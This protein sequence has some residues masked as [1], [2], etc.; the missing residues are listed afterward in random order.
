MPF[1][2]NFKINNRKNNGNKSDNNKE[3]EAK[4]A[5]KVIDIP[6]DE[7]AF[8]VNC[9]KILK[10]D[11]KGYARRIKGI[12][13]IFCS[14]D[15]G[16]EYVRNEKWKDESAHIAVKKGVEK[17]EKMKER[18]FALVAACIVIGIIVAVF[19]SPRMYESKL[20]VKEML[21]SVVPLSMSSTNITTEITVA[22]E[23]KGD[24][25]NVFIDL[26]F[27]DGNNQ[28]STTVLYG[29]KTETKSITGDK[30]QIFKL[31]F[32]ITPGKYRIQLTLFEDNSIDLK[33]EKTIVLESM[34]HSLSEETPFKVTF[35][36]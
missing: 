5:W 33:G 36:K 31:N 1:E 23:G 17:S 6:E 20:N 7:E 13:Y 14:I 25:K 4:E 28:N 22:N 19:V 2:N 8:C 12:D 11:T 24:A 29:G 15:C 27:F 35:H 3:K 9:T 16:E 32:N 34:A 18:L 10:G 30:V 21:F 26:K